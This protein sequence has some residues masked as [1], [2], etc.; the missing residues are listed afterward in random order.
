MHA[1]LKAIFVA[2]L[3]AGSFY[4]LARWMKSRN[5]GKWFWQA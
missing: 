1:I 4:A 2:A 5:G 3:A